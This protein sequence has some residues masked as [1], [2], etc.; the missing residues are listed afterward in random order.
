[1]IRKTYASPPA[2]ALFGISRR[3]GYRWCGIPKY[4]VLQ[5]YPIELECSVRVEGREATRFL[6]TLTQTL[7]EADK[8]GGSTDEPR[9]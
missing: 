3:L 2:H 6:A 4:E 1:M 8:K 9:R 5:I 7:A